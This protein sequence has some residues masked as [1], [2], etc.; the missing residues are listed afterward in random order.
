MAKRIDVD[1]EK[2]ALVGLP[3]SELHKLS[4]EIANGILKNNPDN[5]K[6]A[7]ATNYKLKAIT[8]LIKQKR[9]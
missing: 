2:E 7:C 1:K 8:E 3:V 6:S 4:L 5:Y 9:K